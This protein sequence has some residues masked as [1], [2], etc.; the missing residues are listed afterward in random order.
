MWGLISTDTT[1]TP[2][3]LIGNGGS[4]GAIT[5][6]VGRLFISSG[7]L[8]TSSSSSSGNG[9][10]ITI[11]ATDSIA[12]GGSGSGI[13][14]VSTGGGIGGDI[15]ISSVNDIDV[16]GGAKISANSISTESAGTITITGGNNINVGAGSKIEASAASSFAGGIDI[17]AGNTLDVSGTI[18]AI[19]EKN[20]FGLGT[21]KFKVSAAT[22]NVNQGGSISAITK[23]VAPAG[24]IEFINVAM[25][26]VNGGLISTDT[27]LTPGD[28][29]GNGGLGGAITANVGRLAI[30]GGGR[31]SSSSI[32]SGNGGTITINAT[33]SI[34][35]DGNGSGIFAITSAPGT[36][37]AGDGGNIDLYARHLRMDQGG[38]ISSKSDSTG[39]AGAICI[40]MS[41]C[42]QNDGS[43]QLNPVDRLELRNA[44]VI[45]TSS[46]L[47]TGGNI[48]IQARDLVYLHKSN[49][50]A[51]AQ[52]KDTGDNGGNVTIDPIFVVLNNS[53]ITARA[54]QGFGGDITI[55]ADNFLKDSNSIVNASSA[56]GVQ[57]DG[58]TI[59]NS[60]N[61]DVTAAVT[62]LDASFLNVT[63]LL[64]HRCS[65]ATQRE[66]SSFTVGGRS[67]VARSPDSYFLYNLQH[68][69][70][71][72]NTGRRETKDSMQSARDFQSGL[73]S[74]EL[75]KEIE[76]I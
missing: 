45:E 61:Q 26:N 10:N 71:N 62:I 3:D 70:N 76:C 13:L 25:L 55:T 46:S 48:E 20:P 2:G 65:A 11:N 43:R 23:G 27:T 54:N 41:N 57:F 47:T 32:S 24:H 56:R 8:I 44:S 12:I 30:S 29:I 6:N 21:E 74:Y 72:K 9:G 37:L 75:K 53:N 14:A 17:S 58:Q 68:I 51:S 69:W 5:A 40:G 34:D 35:I 66:R 15:N 42:Y 50:S 60:P 64:R 28:P 1:L 67:G 38:K 22:V 36:P 49:I 52:G 19:N 39:K 16:N 33:D 59:I 18:E 63:G 73:A 4:G 31:I 7:G